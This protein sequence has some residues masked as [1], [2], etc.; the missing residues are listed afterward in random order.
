[1]GV[2]V[3][4]LARA[5]LH[6]ATTTIGRIRREPPVREPTPHPT[7]P[8]PS[9]RRVTAD[10]PNHVWHTDL[11]VVPTNAGLW[12]AAALRPATVLAFL[13]VGRR[14]HGPLFSPSPGW[15]RASPCAGPQTLVK[16]QLVVV[17]DL[18]V[19]SV[20]RRRHLPMVTLSRA[21]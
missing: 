7:Q 19:E 16:G 13:L 9:A 2:L 21:A 15:P 3:Q 10:R 20:A 11:T 8:M 18:N 5:G 6:L 14:R 1:M 4:I 17:L 12:A